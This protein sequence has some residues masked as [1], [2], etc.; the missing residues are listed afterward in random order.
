MADI[1]AEVNHVKKIYRLNI[2]EPGIKGAFRNLAHAR[3]TEKTAL[4]DISFQMKEGQALA[5]IGE[6]GAGN[7]RPPDRRNH[8]ALGPRPGKEFSC[9]IIP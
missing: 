6:N 5:C 8:F 4:D 9:R 7:R 3:W 2:K 1:M